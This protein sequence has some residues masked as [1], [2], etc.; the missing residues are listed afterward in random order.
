[1]EKKTK[2]IILCISALVLTVTILWLAQCLLMP[3]YMSDIPEG[4]LISEYYDNPEGHDVVFV[5]DCEVYENFS[6]VTMWEEYGISS[7]IRGSAQQL[8]WQTYYM[9]E[10]IYRYE[11]PSV[12]V[13]NVLS[14][15]YGE[16]QSEAY[17]RLNLDGMKFSSA[18]LAS[19]RASMTEDEELIT[20]MFPI[21]RYHSRWS[22]L[23][24][25]DLTYMFRR[26]TV[27]H[28]GYLMQKG[29]RPVES[30]PPV[31]PLEKYE[32]DEVCYEYLDKMRELCAAHGS[33]LVLIKAPSL[34]PHWYD[35]WEEQIVT[36]AK[37]YDL[38]Y[39]NLL[40]VCGDIGI[41][42]QKDTYDMGLHLN[43]YGAE[44]AASYF[45]KILRDE[46]SVP[47]RRG[48][49]ALSAYWSEISDRYYNERNG[50]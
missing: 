16:P 24:S 6:P 48:D 10:D 27:G 8:I 17:N 2:N 39:Y 30:L 35:E 1:M 45:G 50:E 43:V 34:Y 12:V 18:K 42:W 32:F 11:T 5:G 25:E 41:D 36:Y 28:A 37:K 4:A 21:L 29:V 22:E 19:V 14:M 15:K 26:D 47:D 46:C 33:E 31:V 38:K 23:T 40:E 7:Y 44:K 3:K 49:A 13:F 9:L 20:Y